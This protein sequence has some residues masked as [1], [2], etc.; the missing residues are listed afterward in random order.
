MNSYRTQ[1]AAVQGWNGSGVI[2]ASPS[3]GV[4]PQHARSGTLVM[5]GVSG[6]RVLVTGGGQGIGRAVAERF[7]RRGRARRGERGRGNPGVAAVG[8]RVSGS[9]LAVGD[10]SDEAAA[11][12]V[13]AGASRCSA[14][15]M[16][17]STTPGIQK[18]CATDETLPADFDRV[19]AVNLR[20]AYLCSRLALRHFLAAGSRGSIINTTSVH[21]VIP[22]PGYVAYSASKAGLGAMTRTLALEYGR[23]GI[24]VNAVAP[25]STETPMNPHLAEAAGRERSAKRIPLGRPAR[26]DEVAGAFVFLASEDAAYVTGHTL[27]VDGGLTLVQRFRAAVMLAPKPTKEL[28]M[29]RRGLL[30]GG[31]GAVA[32]SVE[33]AAARAEGPLIAGIVFQQD[34]FFNGVELGMKAA[35]AKAGATLLLANSESRPEKEISLIDTFVARGVNAIVISPVSA[36]GSEA[37]LRRASAKG[38]KIISYNSRYL[39]WDFLAAKLSSNAADLG[40]TTGEFASAFIKQT[41]GGKAALATLGYRSQSAES[42]DLRINSFIEAARAGG[43]TIDIVAQQDAWLAERAVVIARDVLTAHPEVNVLYAANEGGTVGAVQAVRNA[44]KQ[45]KVF[46]FGIDGS[47][48]L[49]NFLLD[50]DNVL[51]ATTAQRAFLMGE[52]AVQTAV[53]VLDGKPVDKSAD[54]PVLG[55]SRTEPGRR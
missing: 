54:V 19:I 46:V 38:V 14:G 16:C 47:E 53:A 55:L 48:Q 40:R 31:V 17:S 28:N 35:A 4:R 27:Y 34:Q 18:Q 29:N 7:L 39:N 25:G 33:A 3:V 24:R 13:V 10:V 20:G 9:G 44:G 45:G 32:A 42:S 5:R 41:L 43:N 23:R 36:V 8:G 52:E 11:E 6:L 50:K 49:T 1:T 12:R 26:A 15:W 30:L 22:K 21:E 2:E 37:P 51:Q